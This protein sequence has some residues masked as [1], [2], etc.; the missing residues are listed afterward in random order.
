MLEVSSQIAQDATVRAGIAV[1]ASLAD[2]MPD[3][4]VEIGF[5]S[6][7]PPLPAYEINLHAPAAGHNAIADALA[8]QIR[9]EFAQRFGARAQQSAPS[10]ARVEA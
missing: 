2:S 6:G 5:D 8:R 4:L 10:R 1:G 3:T 9:Q 7:L